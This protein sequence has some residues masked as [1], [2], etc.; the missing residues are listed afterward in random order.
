MKYLT[1]IS[2]FDKS[3]IMLQPWADA[4]HNC[5]A[6]DNDTYE[7]QYNN[8]NYVHFNLEC[9][10]YS[11]LITITE[12]IDWMTGKFDG[13]KAPENI[14]DII[15]SFTP[16]T[17]LSVSGARHFEAKRNKDPEFQLKAMQLFR[18]ADRLAK[19][20]G[21]VP[22]I[23]ENPVSVA[24]T[25]WRKSNE[26]YHPY[27]YGGYLPE[28]DIHPKWPEYIPPRDAYP[29]KTGA[30][31]GNGFIMPKKKPVK[32]VHSGNDNFA[33]C[34]QSFTKLG[35]KSAKTKEIRSLTPRGF[36]QA[37]FEANHQPLIDKKR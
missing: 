18:T 29:K 28:N 1:I 15:F 27:E 8:V 5:Y 35:G 23:T 32:P 26:Y 17:D 34:S 22:W 33:N 20:C 9:L 2:L 25:M 11:P 30:W 16:C 21:D 7:G 4:G 24:A 19:I 14:P 6:F 10:L 3:G 37:V 12:L 36:A 13:H 31:Y